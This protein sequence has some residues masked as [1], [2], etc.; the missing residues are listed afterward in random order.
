MDPD[1][2]ADLRRSGGG[3]RPDRASFARRAYSLCWPFILASFRSPA[4]GTC[5]LTSRRAWARSYVEAGAGRA[6]E[7]KIPQA[8]KKTA[9][10]AVEQKPRVELPTKL[11]PPGKGGAVIKNSLEAKE[12]ALAEEIV[13]H[14][15]GKFVGPP[16]K[17]YPGI[18]GTLDGVPVS[19]KETSGGFGA[20]LRHASEAE[21]KARGAGY[22]GVLLFIKAPKIRAA[23]LLDFAKKGPLSSIPK[24]GTISQVNVLTSD[25]WVRIQ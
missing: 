10:E 22:S 4:S 12:A 17:G 18:D 24:Q 6:A 23:S 1:T 20:V 2:L 8:V 11:L 16:R 25:G 13:A 14:Q 3:L 15:G 9:S 21:K 5:G 7:Q 19:L